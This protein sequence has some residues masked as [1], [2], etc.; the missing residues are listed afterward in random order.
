[1]LFEI[2]CPPNSKMIPVKYRFLEPVK[3]EIGENDAEDYDDF[4]ARKIIYCYGIGETIEVFEPD[5]QY[6]VHYNKRL[7]K[8]KIVN[9]NYPGGIAYIFNP[10]MSIRIER[11]V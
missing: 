3:L 2:S 7:K 11:V 10:P 5:L 9:I 4:V 1:M 6:F 8:I